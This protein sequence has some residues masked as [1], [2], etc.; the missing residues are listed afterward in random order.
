MF[1]E[2]MNQFQSRLNETFEAAQKRAQGLET[3]AR[4]V[5][6]TLSDRAQA[7]LKVLL[8]QA[9][10]LSKEQVSQLG[11]ELVKLGT[12]LQEMA[13][14]WKGSNGKSSGAEGAHGHTRKKRSTP[15]S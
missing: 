7:E 4:K 11:A 1:Q 6:E 2:Q 3:E 12:R 5:L 10:G 13:K 9:Q 14:S 15:A 8:A